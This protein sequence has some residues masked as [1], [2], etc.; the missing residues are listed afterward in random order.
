[1]F[2]AITV[3]RTILRIVV[4]QDWSRRAWLYGVGETEFVAR[5]TGRTA[6]R[7]EARGRV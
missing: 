1:M 5:P 6:L 2:T 3:T 7:G 4:R